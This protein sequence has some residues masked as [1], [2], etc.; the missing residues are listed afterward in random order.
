MIA[1]NNTQANGG[2]WQRIMK[3]TNND[4]SIVYKLPPFREAWLLSKVRPASAHDSVDIIAYVQG[5]NSVDLLTVRGDTSLGSTYWQ[6]Y[7]SSYITIGDTLQGDS[8]KLAIPQSVDQ[9]RFVFDG[10]TKNDIIEGTAI[11]NWLFLTKP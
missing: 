6:T 5:K 4:T 11:K 9:I 3:A 10:I 7:D 2:Q 8:K 1:S